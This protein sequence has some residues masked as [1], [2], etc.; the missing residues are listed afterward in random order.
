VLCIDIPLE[1]KTKQNKSKPNKT[2]QVKT[3]KKQSAFRKKGNSMSVRD[4]QR[5][6][7]E[8]AALLL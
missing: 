2:K 4:R 6:G 7:R 1:N 5:T 3:K 8:Q